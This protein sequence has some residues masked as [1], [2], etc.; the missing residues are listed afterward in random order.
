M[1]G[2]ES[3]SSVRTQ[4]INMIKVMATSQLCASFV[5][6]IK[7][8]VVQWNFLSS[9]CASDCSSHAAQLHACLL[10]SES[11]CVHWNVFLGRL[12]I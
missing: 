11:F 3:E 1:G 8:S 7:G 10:D 6:P 12:W 4:V 2:W 9:N 5:T